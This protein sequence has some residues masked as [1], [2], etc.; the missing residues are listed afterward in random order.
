[1]E[2]L[3]DPGGPPPAGTQ[4][5]IAVTSEKQ[6]HIVLWGLRTDVGS[7]RVRRSGQAGSGLTPAGRAELSIDP[8]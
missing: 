4:G 5:C 6:G 1:M 2:G 7:Y 3:T 8:P